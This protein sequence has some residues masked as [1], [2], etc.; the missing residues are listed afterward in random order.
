M[1]GSSL[2]PNI[3]NLGSQQPTSERKSEKKGDQAYKEKNDSIANE[4]EVVMK[5]DKHGR[6]R[7]STMI[8]KR[9]SILSSHMSLNSGSKEGSMGEKFLDIHEN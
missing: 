8:S 6:R 9:A 2:K 5:L 7:L 4:C 1:P 3:L